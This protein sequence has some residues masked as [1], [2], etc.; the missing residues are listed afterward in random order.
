[1]EK[2]KAR[3]GRVM[4]GGALVWVAVLSLIML[5]GS[6]QSPPSGASAA[7]QVDFNWHIRPILADNCLQCHGPNDKSR[8]AK[9]RLDMAESAYAERGAPTRPA[10]ARSFLETPTRAR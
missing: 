7:A 4:A 8:Q 1:M 10:A 2:R 5:D 3:F 9:M 6:A